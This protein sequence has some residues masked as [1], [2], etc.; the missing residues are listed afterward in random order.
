MTR[1]TVLVVTELEVDGLR[2]A[3]ALAD[4]A[5][6]HV[7]RG[8]RDVLA[9]YLEVRPDVVILDLLTD[10]AEPAAVIRQLTPI[11]FRNTAVPFL[12]VVD[13]TVQAHACIAAGARDVVRRDEAATATFASRVTNALTSRDLEIRV[14]SQRQGVADVVVMLANRTV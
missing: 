1:P 5:D 11:G 14:R 13:D 3:A 2:H 6:V 7:H 9:A 8:T 4:V 10:P 12:V